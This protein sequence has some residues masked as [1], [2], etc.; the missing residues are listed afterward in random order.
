MPVTNYSFTSTRKQQQMFG[1][2]SFVLVCITI[3][4]VLTTIHP[5][6][7]LTNRAKRGIYPGFY[8]NPIVHASTHVLLRLRSLLRWCLLELQCR[9]FGE[10]QTVAVFH[11]G[12][13]T[14]SQI[15][16]DR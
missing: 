8:S 16:R 13:L 10:C 9:S 6:L 2:S 3:K 7:D 14:N 11:R 5:C 1:M 12:I 4:L 15:S